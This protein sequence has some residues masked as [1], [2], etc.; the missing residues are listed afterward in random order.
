MCK[1]MIVNQMESSWL[2]TL[3]IEDLRNLYMLFS[4]YVSDGLRKLQ[5]VVIS[6][7]RNTCQ[8]FLTDP[9]RLKDP[10]VYVEDLL[11]TKDKYESILNSP[12]NND[13]K[14]HAALNSFF[15]YIINMNF[16]SPE[17]LPL[18]LDVNLRKGFEG[19]NAEIILDKVVALIGLLHEKDM[20]LKYYKM[21]LAKRLLLGKSVSEDAERSLVVKLKRVCDQQFNEWMLI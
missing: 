9:E 19:V 3:F 8:K 1:E 6:N 11:D 14:F 12:F 4:R 18:F 13:E 7:V 20:F 21:H 2:V 10:M 17:F 16:H 15:E 5:K